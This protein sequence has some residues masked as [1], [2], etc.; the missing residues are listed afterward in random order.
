MNQ[1]VIGEV[2]EFASHASVVAKD[3]QIIAFPADSGAGKTTLA[4]VAVQSGLTYLSDEALVL[5]DDGRAIPYPKPMAL[6]SWS[7][8]LLGGRTKAEETLL[9]PPDLGGY[10]HPGGKP[11]S[12]VVVARYGHERA[13]LSQLPAS[14]AV[15]ELLDKSFNHYKD[16]A[17][18]FRIATDVAREVDVWQ[19]DYDEPRE[20]IELLIDRIT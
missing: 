3:D 13:T 6:S 16:P 9:I 4:A 8:E 18:A 1:S 15:A 2:H 20:A 7:F 5:D 19:L 10:F 11:L 17:R 14:Q 12:H